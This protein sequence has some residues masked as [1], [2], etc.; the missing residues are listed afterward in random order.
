MC[1]APEL[2]HPGRPKRWH[3]HRE[4]RPVHH[5]R[6]TI[7]PFDPSFCRNTRGVQVGRGSG[8]R[9]QAERHP[10]LL[11]SNVQPARPRGGAPIA[12][13]RW[14]TQWRRCIPRSFQGGKTGSRSDQEW[15]SRILKS[16]RNS[17]SP[18][19]VVVRPSRLWSRTQDR[20]AG[21]VGGWFWRTRITVDRVLSRT[22]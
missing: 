10:F 18:L 20:T 19:A 7:F 9:R 12:A 13:A 15:D 6:R 11:S 4:Q 21:L 14:P 16:D 2:H 17:R 5:G 1:C 22:I 8:A 3:G